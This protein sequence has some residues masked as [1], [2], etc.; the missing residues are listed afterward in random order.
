MQ[1]MNKWKIFF[2]TPE[3]GIVSKKISRIIDGSCQFG[4]RYRREPF[5]KKPPCHKTRWIGAEG[6]PYGNVG[7]GTFRSA[8]QCPQVDGDM[9]VGFLKFRRRE[10]CISQPRA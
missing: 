6:N 10:G 3:S 8:S 4:C 1:K 9:P 7:V 5:A 2:S